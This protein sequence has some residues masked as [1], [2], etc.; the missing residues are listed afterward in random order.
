MATIFSRRVSISRQIHAGCVAESRS[1]ATRTHAP[2]AGTT[3]YF[4]AARERDGFAGVC[5]VIAALF[6][7]ELPAASMA[8]T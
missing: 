1:S 6:A 4:P 8:A 2:A 7:E 3:P 5:T